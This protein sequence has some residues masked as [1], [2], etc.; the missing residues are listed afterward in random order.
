MS[1]IS[2]PHPK[3]VFL[4]HTPSSSSSNIPESPF[5]QV[6]WA[7]GVESDIDD[8]IRGMYVLTMKFQGSVLNLERM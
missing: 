7:L 8:P 2:T 1:I 6:S 4:Q 5:P 3:E